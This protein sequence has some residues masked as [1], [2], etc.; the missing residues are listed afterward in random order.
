MGQTRE[1][2]QI[3]Y[4][5]KSETFVELMTRKILFSL[6]QVLEPCF[7]LATLPFHLLRVLV[8]VFMKKLNFE[9][10]VKSP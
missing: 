9:I 4:R 6:V 7:P 3:Y 10:K 8:V 1:E 2:M 5:E